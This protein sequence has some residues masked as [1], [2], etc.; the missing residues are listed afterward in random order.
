[1]SRYRDQKVS[2]Q[3]KEINYSYHRVYES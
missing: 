2:D 3:M 1:M